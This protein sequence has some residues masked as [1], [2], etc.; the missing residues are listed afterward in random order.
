MDRLLDLGGPEGLPVVEV[1]EVHSTRVDAGFIAHASGLK[2]GLADIVAVDVAEDGL[3]VLVEIGLGEVHS[4]I[5]FHPGFELD[6]GG[7]GR[8]EGEE[9]IFFDAQGTEGHSIITFAAG[10]VVGVEFASGSQGGLQPEAGQVKHTERTG[11]TGGN[12]G[13]D[14]AHG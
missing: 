14:L 9:F 2:D 11:N 13:D 10:G 5:S 6:V 1:V 3:I 4:W 12:E 7:L 8:D